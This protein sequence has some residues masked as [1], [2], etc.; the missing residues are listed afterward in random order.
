MQTKDLDL[1]VEHSG[2][3]RYLIRWTD[4][5]SGDRCSIRAEINDDDRVVQFLHGYPHRTITIQ[6][7]SD[8]RRG[9]TRHID[10]TTGQAFAIRL[11]RHI[12]A[13]TG[14]AAAILLNIARRIRTE[15]LA[16]K[17]RQDKERARIAAESK[18]VSEN[19][20]TF[21]NAL[22][23]SAAEYNDTA[24]ALGLEGLS[25]HQMTALAEVLALPEALRHRFA[26]RI[27]TL[28]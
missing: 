23:I 2:G 25:D 12:D 8:D 5:E 11:T 18:R 3:E 15:R 9:L 22:T 27:A 10:A 4:N 21:N 6:A 14:Q 28:I 24:H 26:E 1:T 17:A 16:T 7:I 19:A 20:E 13:T